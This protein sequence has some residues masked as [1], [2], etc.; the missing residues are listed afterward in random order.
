MQKSD[1]ATR[2]RVGTRGTRTGQILCPDAGPWDGPW[3]PVT[4]H[5]NPHTV[6][7]EAEAAPPRPGR[8]GRAASPL[9]GTVRPKSGHPRTRPF[10]PPSLQA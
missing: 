1:R 9:R 8:P 6:L 3:A 5:G 2:L 10:F 7:V 4:L